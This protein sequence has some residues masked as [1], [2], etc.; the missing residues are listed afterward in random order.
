MKLSLRFYGPF[1]I[2][3]R[4]DS[5][6]YRLELPLT[7]QIHLVFQV[8]LLKKKI[9]NNL[10]SIPTRPLVDAHKVLKPELEA[11]LDRRI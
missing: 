4:V 6:A 11:V 10:T 3:S 9:G 8:S 1:Q 2:L 5:I 7:S